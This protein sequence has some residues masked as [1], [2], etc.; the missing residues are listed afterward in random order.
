MRAGFQ[1]LLR[2]IAFAHW[3]NVVTTETRI[4]ALGTF[5]SVDHRPLLVEH[6]LVRLAVQV[7][8][9]PVC[10]RKGPTVRRVAR[11]RTV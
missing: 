1:M 8:A 4:A 7:P 3:M 9:M 6:E 2:C 10:H 5:S 11:R